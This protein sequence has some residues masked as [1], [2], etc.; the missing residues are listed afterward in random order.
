MRPPA[1][2]GLKKC[3]PVGL[4][5]GAIHR[6]TQDVTLTFSTDAGDPQDGAVDNSAAVAYFLVAGVRIT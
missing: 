1:A 6:C 2:R 4:G 3:A 5:F